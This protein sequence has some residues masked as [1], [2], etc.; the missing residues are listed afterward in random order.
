MHEGNGQGR[1]Q[2]RFQAEGD[3]YASG[4]GS[5]DDNT[6]VTALGCGGE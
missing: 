2:P 4:A 3:L 1:T 6:E 5:N